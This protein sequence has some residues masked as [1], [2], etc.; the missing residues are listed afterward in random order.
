MERMSEAPRPYDPSPPTALEA[1]LERVG[2]RW[3]LLLVDALLGA[4]VC[5]PGQ[6]ERDVYFPAGRWYDW[7]TGAAHDGPADEL[8]AAPLDCL[9]LFGRG[10]TVVPLATVDDDG[11]IDDRS[12]T[13]RVFPGD[14]AGSIYDDDGETFDY[15]RGAFAVRRYRVIDVGHATVISLAEVEGEFPSRRRLVVE[16]PDGATTE[17][18]DTGGAVDVTLTTG[19]AR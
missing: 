19:S 9:P 1:A 12:L 15:R 6:R 7:W 17:L 2:D 13:L 14:G 16:S 4:P 11:R 10:G 3:S 8:V 18:L 5:H